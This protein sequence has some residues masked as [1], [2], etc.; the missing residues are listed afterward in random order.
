MSY[1]ASLNRSWASMSLTLG[2]FSKFPTFLYSIQ[3]LLSV[4]W[5]TCWLGKH[6]LPRLAWAFCKEDHEVWGEAMLFD[7][8]TWISLLMNTSCAMGKITFLLTGAV[9]SSI[10]HI[11]AL[12]S[13]VRS[14]RVVVGYELPF[15]YRC[16]KILLWLKRLQKS[17]K[18]NFY[19][20]CRSL[21]GNAGGFPWACNA[22]VN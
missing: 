4:C 3:L 18:L 6:L 20:Y 12:L 1:S 21:G 5:V 11:K 10:S 15:C 9:S 7:W 2:K 22:S 16:C 17:I 14:G 13:A 8:L 19:M